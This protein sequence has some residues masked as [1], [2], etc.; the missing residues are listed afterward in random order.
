MKLILTVRSRVQKTA[1]YLPLNEQG[2]NASAEILGGNGS[3]K[4]PFKASIAICNDN[5]AA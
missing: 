3:P 4:D 2:L 5:M 1:D